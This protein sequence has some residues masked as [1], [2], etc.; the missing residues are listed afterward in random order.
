LA[1]ET[2]FVDGA[3]RA[4]ILVVLGGVR[5]DVI[6]ADRVE[7]GPRGCLKGSIETRQLIVQEGAKLDGDC[8]I[9]PARATVHVL[10]PR[11]TAEPEEAADASALSAR[12]D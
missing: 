2:G 3:V 5:G 11:L 4:A 12:S 9:A 1:G 7:I 10:R 6:A 8:R